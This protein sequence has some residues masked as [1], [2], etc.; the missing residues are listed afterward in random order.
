MDSGEVKKELKD[1]IGMREI[2]GYIEFEHFHGPLLHEK[3]V[4]LNCGRNALAYLILAKDIKKIVLP[5]FLCNSVRDVCKKYGVSVRFYH[6]MEDFFPADVCLEEDEWLYVVNYYGQLSNDIILQLKRKYSRIVVDNAQAYFDAPVEG[7]PTIYTCRK[8]FGV[9]DGAMLYTDTFLDQDFIKDE[10]YPR[11]GFLLGRFE[12]T[13]SEFYKEYAD[14]N[15][16]FVSEPI[17]A[18][19]ALTE[20]LLRAV[21]YDCVKQ[22]RT[23]NYCFL[24]EK[25][26]DINLLKLRPVEGGFAYPLLLKNGEEIRKKM[27]RQKI[28]I[29]TLWPNVLEDVSESAVEY[30]FTKNILPL[31]CDQRYSTEDM[32]EICT[33]LK[34]L[35]SESEA[36]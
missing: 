7:V 9:A 10:S 5:Y 28:Y 27:I 24:D 8:F 15:H 23:E 25:L 26:Q 35:I 19:S 6:I 22:V 33:L 18:M 2:G 31:P 17:K 12:R 32:A 1:W 11:M 20:N 36:V 29:P 4:K 14:N 13:A 34:K 3:A 30:H 21:D 16:F